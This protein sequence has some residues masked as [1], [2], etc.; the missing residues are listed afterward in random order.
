MA[1]HPTGASTSSSAGTDVDEQIGVT[2][3][4]AAEAAKIRETANRM[5]ERDPEDLTKDIRQLAGTVQQLAEQVER[6]AAAVANR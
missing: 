1:E 5:A 4:V 2:N 3:A 6:L